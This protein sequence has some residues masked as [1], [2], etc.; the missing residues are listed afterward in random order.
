MLCQWQISF[1]FCNVYV[2]CMYFFSLSCSP[3][4]HFA[5]PQMAC[6]HFVVVKGWHQRQRTLEIHPSEP[7]RAASVYPAMK[8][9]DH[10][11]IPT[12]VLSLVGSWQLTQV[13]VRCCPPFEGCLLKGIAASLRSVP[14]FGPWSCCWEVTRWWIPT[15]LFRNHRWLW[16]DP[17]SFKGCQASGESLWWV[18]VWGATLILIFFKG[19][20]TLL[21]SWLIY[22][23]P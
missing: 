19:Q 3:V 21:S 6:V 7:T 13:G 20:I 14:C 2:L 5:A 17:L 4:R 23:L 12:T 1:G 18:A 8:T 22:L 11:G 16:K 15:Q 9:G 10:R